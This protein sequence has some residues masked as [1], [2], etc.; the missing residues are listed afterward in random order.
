M[1]PLLKYYDE[2]WLVDFEFTTRG[3]AHNPICMAAHELRTGRWLRC[4][5]QGRTPP[6]CPFR[7]DDRVLYVSYAASADI[8]GHLALGW[9][10]PRRVLDLYAEYRQYLNLRIISPPGTTHQPLTG[11]LLDALGEFGLQHQS[12]YEEKAELQLLCD[13]N[14]PFDDLT[15]GRILSHCQ[16]DVVALGELLGAMVPHLNLHE[17]LFR[18]RYMSALASVERLGIPLDLPLVEQLQVNWDAILHELIAP[19]DGNMDIFHHRDVSQSKLAMWLTDH[20]VKDWPQTSAGLLSTS[21]ETLKEMSIAYPATASL[22]ELITTARDA[23]LFRGLAIS[24]DG[25]NRYG[26]APFATKTGR[27]ASSS[28]KCILLKPAWVRNLIKPP[29]GYALLYAD[30]ISQEYGIAAYLSRDETMI[31]DYESGDPYL[32]LAIRLNLAPADANKSSHPN[33]RNRMKVACG[34]GA[35]YGA[36]VDTVSRIGRMEP[37][38][39]AHVLQQHRRIYS[40]YWRWTEEYSAAA[41]FSGAM[42]SPLGWRWAPGDATSR[43][44]LNWPMQ[45]SGADMLRLAVCLAVERGL[46]VVAPNHDALMVEC[47]ICDIESTRSL[48]LQCMEEASRYVL[49][50]PMLKVEI[51]EPIV[52]PARY[53]L[54]RGIAMFNRVCGVLD[55]LTRPITPATMDLVRIGR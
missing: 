6:R 32:A 48:L 49:N 53:T 46:G 42:R 8:R 5:F 12:T 50:G 34:L 47:R 17:A 54:P 13:C 26:S 51:N 7:F 2:I 33:L 36:G 37:S 1:I 11:G 41:E 31:A 20:G 35:L 19:G 15:L 4:N 45:A 16:S 23:K 28:A 21:Q 25:R 40:R 38:M 24:P 39:A 29:P 52:Y 14:A 18:G 27:N 30:W 10:L 43:T 9:P 55:G 44:I 22:R 3:A